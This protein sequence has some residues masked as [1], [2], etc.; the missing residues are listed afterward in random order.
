M[1]VFTA[2]GV[3]I[4][5][6]SFGAAIGLTAASSAFLVGLVA[7]V[8][9]GAALRALM[10]K[11][12]AGTNRGYETTA[13][14]TALD[15]Q[16]IYGK[17]RVAGARIYDEATGTDNK[18]L[19]RIVA[20]AG[21]EIE[22][23]DKIY[24][25]DS[26]VNF[27]D[28]G[29]DG[30]LS[31]V[32]D[33]DGTTSD[34]YDDHVKINFH[35]GSPT[36]GAD[37]DLIGDSAHWTS[38]HKLSG[39][40]YMY[41]RLKYS[42][43]VFPNGIPEFTAEVKGKK[44]Y[45]PRTQTTSWSDNPALCVRD[46]LTSSYGIS[47]EVANVDDGLVITAADVCDQTNTDAGTTRYTCNGAF[48]TASTPYD[49]INAML[50]SMDGSLW[51]A[52]GKWRMK[53]AY[54]T[55]PVLDL[56]EDDLRSSISVSTR[57]SRRD[58]FN[59]VKG[60][61]RGEESNWQTTDY[62]QVTNPVF[63]TADGGQESVADVDLPFTDNSIE[64]RRIARISLERNR[65]QL[66]VNASFGLKTLQVQVG[67]NIR[68]TNSRFGWDNKEFEVLSWNFGLTDGL[69]LQTQMTLRETAE[70]VYD[71]VDDGIVYERDNTT[72]PSAFETAVPQSF[73]AFANTFVNE[74]GTTVPELS[75]TWS[76]VNPNLVDHYEFQW[77]FS[78]ASEYNSSLVTEP[79]FLLSPAESNKSYDSRVRSVNALGVPSQ[80]INS[81]SPINT[82]NDTTI[83]S[84][85][86]SVNV[87]G[88]YAATT[89]EWTAPTT[90]TDSSAIKDLFQYAVYRGT[91]T[92]PTTLVGR[93]SGTTFSDIGLSDDTTYYYR[94]KAF[95]FTGNPSAYS[96]NGSGTTNPT[97]IDGIDGLNNATVF[98]YNKS[99]SATAPALFS[100]TFTYT[101]STGVLSGGTLNGWT[102]EPPTLSQGDNLWVSL[103]TASSRTAT[104]TV[105]TAEFSTPEI[106][107]F[108]G[109]D[110]S[111]TAR[112]SLFRKTSTNS[113]PADPSG[114]FTYTFATGVLSG[115]TLNSWSQSAPS[116]NN[117]EYLWAIQASAF[118]SAAT[119]TIAATE[120]TSASVVG[121]GG[122]NGNP[123][124]LLVLNAT[125]QV[126]TY[127]EN[128]AADPASQTITFT[129]F[130]ENTTDTT[131]TWS[132]SPS[133]T[134][135]GT[136]NTRS[137]SVANFGSNTSVTVTA[138][139]DSNAVSD[140]FT[141][142]RLKDGTTGAT[143]DS[144]LTLILSNEAH[145]FAA[146]NGGIVSSYSGSGTTIK[147]FE[148]TTELTYN[149][150]S[151]AA[152]TWSISSAGTNITVGSVTDSGDF[153]T[154]GSHSS[155]TA[156]AA[157]IEYTITGKRADGSAISL[158]KTQSFS[159]SK[160]GPAG[161]S[162]TGP[163]GPR[164]AGR[165]NIQVSTLPTTSGSANTAF[166]AAIGDPV[167]KDQAWF[168]VGTQSAPTSQNVW[169]YDLSST[170]WVEQT[171][172]ID[173]ELLVSGTITGDK[174][175]ANTITAGNISVTQL[176]AIS[177][178]IG[179]FSSASTGARLVL[180][181]DK[182]LVY[183]NSNNIRVK[184]GDLS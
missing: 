8:V 104:D 164:G 129:A 150:G 167:D 154:V 85:P 145:T 175:A 155:M 153:A 132:S 75:F 84:A 48:T 131:A 168:Y 6:S 133:V 65:Q 140:T 128:N 100:G 42:A 105:P 12:S 93:V 34:R 158:T 16:V 110:G 76:V 39:I 143:G 178:T 53:P 13:L 79:K 87:S 112:V 4:I 183:D 180:Q 127:D 119:D 17:M 151:T 64:A 30:N 44:V 88:G 138:S 67:D 152:S 57:H 9:L 47:E 33:A 3:A 108:A 173:G 63:V 50:T 130:L 126:F 73:S 135:T 82:S 98:L 123:A 20:I 61:F 142:Y 90:N 160:V 71:E 22:S 169:I 55:T 95:D 113:A 52:Q 170:A 66:T 106:T 147:L 111:N 14:G 184:I 181:D 156:D 32:T 163:D 149:Q 101:F 144:A 120:F 81:A 69:D 102:Q 58:N 122:T 25:D 70:S 97:L 179:T 1:V 28:I 78:D 139:A 80:W 24:I 62:P 136:G 46:Y 18:Y 19:H 99:S 77:K 125:D 174:V 96:I 94:V 146:D 116:L 157:S 56:N 54:W 107:G 45:D 51:Y 36:Q 10:P 161:A 177:A 162:V 121:I 89:V 83:P 141:V 124:K 26:Y 74:D 31:T 176:D 171:E 2:A 137:L 59:T 118:S 29:A 60:T 40:A 166:T 165:W 91:S 27:S 37:T 172:V 103:A 115:G 49:M 15:H 159:K 41:I 43:D 134:L 38:A 148:G 117:D 5:G 35:Y 68:L 23:F 72:L 109:T 11:P 86:T 182:I 92:N 7:N 114:T 21:H